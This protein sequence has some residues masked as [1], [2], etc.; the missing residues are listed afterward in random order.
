MSAVLESPGFRINAKYP[1]FMQ[2]HYTFLSGSNAGD[3]QFVSDDQVA[4]GGIQLGDAD[5]I[6]VNF[7]LQN[8]FIPITPLIYLPSAYTVWHIFTTSS[9]FL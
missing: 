8:T 9:L 7:Q 2:C 5:T 3:W 1:T 4:G 6:T